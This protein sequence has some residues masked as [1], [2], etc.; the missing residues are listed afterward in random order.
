MHVN[1]GLCFLCEC[2]TPPVACVPSVCSKRVLMDT[3]KDEC[4]NILECEK[5]L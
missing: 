2:D 5:R 3:V 4:I 1:V